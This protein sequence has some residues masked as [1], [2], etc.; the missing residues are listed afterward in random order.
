MEEGKFTGQSTKPTS[1][2]IRVESPSK[3]SHVFTKG[4]LRDILGLAAIQ[5]IE[6]DSESEAESDAL[7]ESDS[8]ASNVEDVM[9][10]FEDEADVAAMQGAKKEAN[11]ELQEFDETIQYDKEVSGNEGRDSQDED[12]SQTDGEAA[13]S[14]TIKRKT[15]SG[16]GSVDDEASVPDDSTVEASDTEADENEFEAWQDQVGVDIS[17]LEESLKPTE[18]Y[19]LNFK[20]EIDPYYSSHFLTEMQ[21]M[22]ENEAGEDRVDLD[23][24]EEMK[25]EEEQR[26][27]EQGELLATQPQLASLL[28]Q[29][30]LYIREKSRLHS[31]KKRRKLLG[32]NWS[33]RHDAIHNFPFWYNEDTGEATWDK[34]QI[35]LE[36]EAEDLARKEGWNLFPV[37][38]LLNIMDFLVPYPDRTHCGKVCRQWRWAAGDFSFVKHVWP[39]EMGALSMNKS[40]LE[41]NHYVCIEDAL[42]DS[43]PGDTIELGDGHYWVNS[44]GL[45]VNYPI[46]FL[47]DEKDP[48]H[49][50]IELSGSIRWKGRG[51]WIEGVTVRRSKVQ[52]A[53]FDMFCL[54]ESGHFDMAHCVFDNARTPHNTIRLST[55]GGKSSWLDITITGATEN[56]SGLVLEGKSTLSL[57]KVSHKKVIVVFLLSELMR[58]IAVTVKN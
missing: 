55:V 39:V 38:P 41:K 22:Q 26:A 2:S 28:R 11:D 16:K 58:L 48:S 31:E 52:G 4:G 42:L 24:I 6:D 56:Y 34:P 21:G 46:R 1:Q 20:E 51:G 49:V 32:K 23:V 3:V 37:K 40:R 9:A 10:A 50:V 13:K 57:E 36:L 17:T 29:R 54:E 18:R 19:A 43:L 33:L 14:A 8:H 12:A 27:I 30:H 7:V 53:D 25:A 45:V 35:I 15:S 44:P 47:G 5:S